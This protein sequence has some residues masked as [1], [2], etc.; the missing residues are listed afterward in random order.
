MTLC[1]SINWTAISAIA[2][3]LMI[4]ITGISIVCSNRQNRDNR[5]ANYDQNIQNR[6]LQVKLLS[7]E[8]AQSRLDNI[9]AIIS[10]LISFL[11]DEDLILVSSYLEENTQPILQTIKKISSNVRVEITNLR[12]ALHTF[13]DENSRTYLKQIDEMYYMFRNMLIDLTWMAEYSP[14]NIKYDEWDNELIEDTAKTIEEDINQYLKRRMA[15]TP[16]IDKYDASCI[17][18]IFKE[19][20]YS[21]L[22]FHDIWTTRIMLFDVEK[23]E[24]VSIDYMQKELENITSSL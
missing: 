7:A 4:I 10:R 5:S 17:W 15:D 21:H 23:F 22:K 11:E 24:E 6:N 9:R 19:F 3:A 14:S 1:I 2:S 18:N 13:N 16:S 12:L 20:G 8:L